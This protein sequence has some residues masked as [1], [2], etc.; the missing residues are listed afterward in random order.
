MAHPINPT[1]IFA[2]AHGQPQAQSDLAM[3]FLN[4]GGAAAEDDPELADEYYAIAEVFAQLACSHGR[5]TDVAL[6][7]GVCARRAVH[8]ELRDPVRALQYREAAE[9]LFNTIESGSDTTALG[10]VAATLNE[11][12]DADP[13]DDLASARLN[14]IIERLPVADAQA[15]RE[16]VRATRSPAE[17]QPERQ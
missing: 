12:A 5:P 8:L 13:E 1:Y 11:L 9:G 3:A 6:L 4:R 2:A 17:P 10:I 16:A 7:A 15:L 14:R